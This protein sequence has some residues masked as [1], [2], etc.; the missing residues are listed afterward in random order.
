MVKKT[1]DEI[2]TTIC[3]VYFSHFKK[4]KEKL[5]NLQKKYE[6]SKKK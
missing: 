6:S 5:A 3:E 1:V 4:L 2:S